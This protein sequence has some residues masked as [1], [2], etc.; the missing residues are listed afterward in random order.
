MIDFLI[1]EDLATGTVVWWRE[2]IPDGVAAAVGIRTGIFF[3]SVLSVFLL[4]T[5]GEE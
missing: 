5:G 3:D 4:S 2:T 1:L